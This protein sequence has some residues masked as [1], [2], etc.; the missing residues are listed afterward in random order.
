MLKKF[1]KSYYQLLDEKIENWTLIVVLIWVLIISASMLVKD[2]EAGLYTKNNL[3]EINN[4]SS[5][6]NNIYQ[7]SVIEINWIR[8]KI[9]LEEIQSIK[10]S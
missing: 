10:N 8:Y 5:I 2:T 4:N 9:K 1:I 7:D 3:L 6:Y